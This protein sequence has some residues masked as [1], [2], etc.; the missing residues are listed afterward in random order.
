M[1]IKAHYK[2]G[3]SQKKIR[4]YSVDKRLG[5]ILSIIWKKKT[6]SERS[7]RI[8]IPISKPMLLT[9]VPPHG[10]TGCPAKYGASKSCVFIFTG[11]EYLIS[12]ICLISSWVRRRS[13]KL[14]QFQENVSKAIK[15]REIDIPFVP[16][17]IQYNGSNLHSCKI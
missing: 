7:F 10:L 14:N 12:S 8:L 11:L 9:T 13:E 2:E 15:A 1:N 5:S 6:L 17:C 16:I 4:F 3:L